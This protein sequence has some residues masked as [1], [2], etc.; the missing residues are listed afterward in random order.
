[1]DF[2][3]R[4]IFLVFRRNEAKDEQVGSIQYTGYDVHWPSGGR[5]RG[6]AF[7]R[8]CKIGVRYLLG[9]DK[10]DLA[11]M[12]LYNLPLA[13]ADAP[14]PRIPGCRVRALYLERVGADFK[15][16]LSDGSPTDITFNL[17][18]DEKRVLDWLGARFIADGGRQWFGMYAVRAAVPGL[19][20]P[21][22]QLAS[23]SGAAAY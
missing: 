17:Y 11:A 12:R 4:E 13:S 14:L 10:P 15:L 3:R 5:V 1:M 6:L 8:F 16:F 21:V 22:T 7:D 23:H 20:V 19:S 9:R 18:R 2:P